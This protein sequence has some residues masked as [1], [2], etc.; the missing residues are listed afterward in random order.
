M[1]KLCSACTWLPV[2]IQV[3]SGQKCWTSACLST[4]QGSWD[5]L[6]QGLVI[7]RWVRNKNVKSVWL[8]W[9]NGQRLVGCI[10]LMC[11]LKTCSMF[12]LVPSDPEGTICIEWCGF[13]RSNLY[14]LVRKTLG[15]CQSRCSKN[16]LSREWATLTY[17]FSSCRRLHSG[18]RSPN[19]SA[20]SMYA[21]L[22]TLNERNSI[23]T[24]NVRR[25]LSTLNER[26]S[27]STFNVRCSLSTLNERNSISTFNV[28]RSKHPQWTQPF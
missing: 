28:R 4:L 17:T 1:E 5:K 19:R 3:M 22:S 20:P 14:L 10:N 24:F 15:I 13:N 26:N 2:N 8:G 27:I 21:T 6:W 25:S 18:H 12:R 16:S 9:R 23:S 11:L 7:P